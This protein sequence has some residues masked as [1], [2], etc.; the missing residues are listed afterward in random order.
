M[1]KIAMAGASRGSTTTRDEIESIQSNFAA[2]SNEAEHLSIV[3]SNSLELTTVELV[4]DENGKLGHL[5]GES[6]RSENS[7]VI[8]WLIN[9]MESS[10]GKSFMFI[11][12]AKEVWDVV[13]DTY[14]DMEN[15][16]QIF[17]L[18]TKLW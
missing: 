14:S 4:I 18:K 10:I 11:P 5:I 2:L 9:S 17:E 8:A 12:I 6:W 3:S 7:K 13:R 1:V 16:S 15:S